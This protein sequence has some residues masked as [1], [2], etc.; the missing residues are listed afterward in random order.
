MKL[1]V[2]LTSFLI[3]VLLIS[4]LTKYIQQQNNTVTSGIVKALDG[5]PMLGV[6]IVI[7]NTTNGMIS[8]EN[9]RFLI[10]SPVN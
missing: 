3:L 5:N 10:T 1:S 7:E 8:S 6:Q 4:F 9:G 2:S